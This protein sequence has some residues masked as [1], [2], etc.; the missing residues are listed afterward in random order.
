MM[1]ATTARP[2]PIGMLMVQIRCNRRDCRRA[3]RQHVPHE[4]VLGGEDRIR[5]RGNAARQRAGQALC[6]ISLR[7]SQQMPEQVAPQIAGNADK[8]KVR[9][10][11][12]NP[13]EQIIRSDQRSEECERHPDAGTLTARQYVNEIFH[14]VLR[15]DR[16]TDGS[17]HGGQDHRMG[18]RAQPD[19]ADHKGERT[20]GENTKIGHACVVSALLSAVAPLRSAS[21]HGTTPETRLR[22]RPIQQKLFQSRCD[23]ARFMSNSR[24]FCDG[25][26]ASYCGS[27]LRCHGFAR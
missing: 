14:A 21:Y 19:I 24:R 10:P 2:P 17:K 25:T 1:P 3:G 18:N 26:A 22:T 6:K 13:P 8:C 16:A 5:G 23:G 11:T 9:D 15:T 27:T 12:R 4:H 7:M 20:N